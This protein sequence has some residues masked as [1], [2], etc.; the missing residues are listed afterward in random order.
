MSKH[1][2]FTLNDTVAAITPYEP[3]KPT[4]ELERELG[5]SSTIKLASN[6]NPLGPSLWGPRPSPWKRCARRLPA[7]TATRTAVPI[8]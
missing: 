8:T 4:T 3:G 6:E 7:A 2:P 1:L 5:L